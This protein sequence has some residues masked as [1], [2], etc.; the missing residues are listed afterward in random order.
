MLVRMKVTKLPAQIRS[1]DLTSKPVRFKQ[2]VCAYSVNC[3][4]NRIRERN[5][6]ISHFPAPSNGRDWLWEPATG[7]VMQSVT[8]P[9]GQVLLAS[10]LAKPGHRKGSVTAQRGDTRYGADAQSAGRHPE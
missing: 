1:R 2:S 6:E 9:R 5:R 3:K 7:L 10:G 4:H 8:I